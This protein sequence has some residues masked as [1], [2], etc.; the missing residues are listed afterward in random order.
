MK[1]IIVLTIAAI[2]AG[3]AAQ[4]HAQQVTTEELTGV[5]NFKRLETTVACAGATTARAMPAIQKMGF[6]SVVNL[7]LASEEGV[8]IEGA[9]AAAKAV[10]LNYIHIPFSSQ[11][12]EVTAADRFLAEIAKP[13]NE[14]AFIHCGGGGR[15]ATMWFIKRMVVDKWDV[16]RASAEATAL[17]MNNATL[18]QWAIDYAKGKR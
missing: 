8:D 7:R 1:R 11:T 17:G 14:P 13:A 9:S 18:K 2:A 5:R 3:V 15:A 16:D 4:L 10:N 12:P 6:R